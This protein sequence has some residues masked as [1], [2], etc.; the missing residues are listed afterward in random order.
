M[1]PFKGHY[2]FA[3]RVHGFWLRIT[4]QSNPFDSI[5]STL[6]TV[7][8]VQFFGMIASSTCYKS[9]FTSISQL[10]TNPYGFALYASKMLYKQV[11]A[12]CPEQLQ[13]Q[14]NLFGK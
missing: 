5:E 11:E 4:Y 10:R 7:V 2:S 3:L 12:E 1:F 8:R 6:S 13:R 9:Y 14:L